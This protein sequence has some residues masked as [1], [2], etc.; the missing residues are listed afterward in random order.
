M[1]FHRKSVDG[2]LIVVHISLRHCMRFFSSLLIIFSRPNWC[3][4][5]WDGAGD[6]RW[7]RIQR[8]ATKK[9]CNE[10]STLSVILHAMTIS[11]DFWIHL[12][13]FRFYKHLLFW[14]S[15]TVSFQMNRFVLLYTVSRMTIFTL[16]ND[17]L[18]WHSNR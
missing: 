13:I 16:P 6:A 8:D 7:G 10:P 2:F 1:W 5:V 14:L 12:V 9:S 11:F 18:F 15:S 3:W 4:R 17:S